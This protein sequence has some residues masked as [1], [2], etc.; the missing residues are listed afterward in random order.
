MY[1]EQVKQIQFI[2]PCAECGINESLV[3][4]L[5]ISL[6]SETNHLYPEQVKR[7]V[8]ESISIRHEKSGIVGKDNSD[9]T[10]IPNK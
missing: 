1:L 4:D 3:A 2:T 10:C 8:S 6:I 5:E 7:D 9:N